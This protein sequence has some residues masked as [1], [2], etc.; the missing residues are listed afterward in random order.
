MSQL[1]TEIHQQPDALARLLDAQRDNV[2]QIAAEIRAFQPAF[3]W[4][5]ARGT[6]DNAA[7]YAQYAWGIH[8]GLAVGLATPSVHTLYDSAPNLSKAV[9]FGISQSGRGDDVRT[10]IEHAR[11]QGALTIAITNDADSP[12]A[13]AAHHHISLETGAEIAV[14]ATKTYTAELMVVAMLTAA[15]SDDH[16][17]RDQLAQVPAY[18]SETLALN[19]SLQDWIAD[20]APISEYAVIGRGYNYCTAYEISLKIKELC[21]IPG[22][23]YSEAD[24]LH[25]PIA[26]VERDFPV[27]TVAAQGKTLSRQ[28]ELIEKLKQRGANV[29]AIT[30]ASQAAALA[31]HTLHFS[32]DI[33]EWLSPIVAVMPGQE[34]AM[35]LAASKGYDVDRPRG[36]TKVTI[37]Q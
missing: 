20:F 14:A 28:L 18:A 15:L 35:S 12:V 25:G 17:L 9:V 37:T 16:A 13:K 8:C 3:A 31:A 11:A 34:F 26:V 36:L 7:R 21:Y 4:I 33:P 27:L 23:E 29:L 24:F 10:V 22:E 1:V 2:Q 6:S 5:A 32:A 19:P 30:N